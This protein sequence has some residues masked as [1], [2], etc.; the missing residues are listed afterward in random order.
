MLAPAARLRA[1]L[2]QVIRAEEIN[3]HVGDE[4][5]VWSDCCGVRHRDSGR[6]ERH[7]V[8]GCDVRLTPVMD[9]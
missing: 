7:A 5:A 8:D 1:A 9:N 6:V 2:E 4:R 3:R